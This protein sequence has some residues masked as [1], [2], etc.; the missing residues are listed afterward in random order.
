MMTKDGVNM[1]DSDGDTALRVACENGHVECVTVL[2]KDKRT[3]V[4]QCTDHRKKNTP[5]MIACQQC[6]T[7]TA[8]NIA[9]LENRIKICLLLIQ[10]Q[11][12][13]LN[14][15]NKHG[16]TALDIIKAKQPYNEKLKIVIDAL[17]QRTT[18]QVILQGN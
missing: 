10:H 15:K 18:G 2:I 13:D 16:N 17:N 5:L 7:D 3:N 14:L 12:I 4:N 1:T 9:Q 11:S 8:H 6:C